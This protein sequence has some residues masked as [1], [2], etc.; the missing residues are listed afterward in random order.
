MAQQ[1]NLYVWEGSF[2]GTGIAGI[3]FEDSLTG[4]GGQSIRV[5]AGG[6]GFEYYTPGTGDLTAVT[7]TSPVVV[8]SG[9]GPIPNISL[10]G[11]TSFGSEDQ[12]IISTGAGWA[13]VSTTGT[14]SIVRSSSP[15]LTGTVTAAAITMSG[16]LTASGTANLGTVSVSNTLNVTE[17]ANFGHLGSSAFVL[18]IDPNGTPSI[19]V[20]GSTTVPQQ[21]NASGSVTTTLANPTTDTALF[22]SQSNA[23]AAKLAAIETA[24]LAYGWLA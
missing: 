23:N 4:L 24:L 7:V 13:Y 3:G 2:P 9:T 10:A 21:S 5:N 20:F 19:G 1:I 17:E 18:K 16:T 22:L 12:A 14:S 6:T 15:T 8:S 11:L